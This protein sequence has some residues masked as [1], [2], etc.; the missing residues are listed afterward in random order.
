MFFYEKKKNLIPKEHESHKQRNANI[1]CIKNTI[2]LVY[3]SR[4][5]FEVDFN[6]F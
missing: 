4:V 1:F 2:V 5:D 3:G 6:F